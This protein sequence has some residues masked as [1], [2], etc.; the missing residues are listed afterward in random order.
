[1]FA[2]LSQES[3][4]KTNNRKP[5]IKWKMIIAIWKMRKLEQFTFQIKQR[6]DKDETKQNSEWTI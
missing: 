6:D 4:D 5:L 3:K 1:M 2:A